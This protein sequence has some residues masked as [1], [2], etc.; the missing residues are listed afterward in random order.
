VPG[1][2]PGT[3]N[4]HPFDAV[5]AARPFT[6]DRR[7]ARAALTETH[8]AVAVGHTLIERLQRQASAS[9]RYV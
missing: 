5:G 7:S 9:R 6:P 8:P 4:I 3:R 1:P 2:F